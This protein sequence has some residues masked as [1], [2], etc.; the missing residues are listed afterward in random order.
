MNRSTHAG[1]QPAPGDHIEHDRY[2]DGLVRSV[3][4]KGEGKP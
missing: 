2:R 1:P 4:H 3:V